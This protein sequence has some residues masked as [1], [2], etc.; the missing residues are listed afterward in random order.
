MSVSDSRAKL[1]FNV[2]VDGKLIRARTI[3]RLSEMPE[4]LREQ[5][6]LFRSIVR[7]VVE[8]DKAQVESDS[9]IVERKRTERK[10]SIGTKTFRNK[11]I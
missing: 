6:R 9:K 5:K 4:C 3:A 10:D 2:I 8:H 1:K 11:E 7:K